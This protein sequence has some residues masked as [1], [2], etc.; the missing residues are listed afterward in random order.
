MSRSW[1]PRARIGCLPFSSPNYLCRM[2]RFLSVDSMPA[3]LEG[4][5][6]SLWWLQQSR[7]AGGRTG[8]RRRALCNSMDVRR[9][10]SR[11]QRR[12]VQQVR[13]AATARARKFS[14]WKAAFRRTRTGAWQALVVDREAGL[15]CNSTL[16][17]NSGF[18]PGMNPCPSR[19]PQVA[20]EEL[21]RREEEEEEEGNSLKTICRPSERG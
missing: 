21:F 19:G 16:P 18:R 13:S 14:P 8:G 12:Q 10:V 5:S 7:P 3:M 20:W 17:G 6:R 15:L 1:R 9:G 4:V 2:Q 11:Q